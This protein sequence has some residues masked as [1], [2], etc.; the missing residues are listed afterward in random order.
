MPSILDRRLLLALALL[1]ALLRGADA[2][3]V[4]APRPSALWVRAVAEEAPSHGGSIT[5]M[6]RSLLIGATIGVVVSGVLG[7][8]A[9]RAYGASNGCGGETVWWAVMGGMLGA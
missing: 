9:C 3:S 7:Q 1:P 2:Q 4:A 6:E 8:A 5:P